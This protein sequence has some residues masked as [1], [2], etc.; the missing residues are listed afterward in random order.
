M[1]ETDEVAGHIICLEGTKTPTAS[2]SSC[3]GLHY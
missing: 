3:L 2:A 1:T